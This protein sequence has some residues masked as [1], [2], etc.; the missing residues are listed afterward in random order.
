M[1]HSS[2][3]WILGEDDATRP[4]QTRPEFQRL[5]FSSDRDP[6]HP[7]IRVR[8]AESA[9]P[10]IDLSQDPL[11]LGKA[12]AERIVLCVNACA[13]LTNDELKNV[14]EHKLSINEIFT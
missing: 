14:I 2:E 3:P 4:G 10:R 12:N 13:G 11:E 6:H 9:I 1:K 7:H 8:V 5:I